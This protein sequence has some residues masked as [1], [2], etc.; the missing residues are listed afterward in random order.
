[1]CVRG[2]QVEWQAARAADWGSWVVCS[3]QACL[4]HLECLS[5]PEVHLWSA[6]LRVGFLADST[7]FPQ[8]SLWRERPPKWEGRW[9]DHSGALGP[10]SGGA[11]AAKKWG[12]SLHHHPL[13]CGAPLGQAGGGHAGP[14]PH[15]A[16]PRRTRGIH[17][18]LRPI[19]LSRHSLNH[20]G[21]G[22]A[23]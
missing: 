22:C 11:P 5:R 2:R 3:L 9:C 6:V 18:N 21:E 12:R 16:L 23:L 1:M 4:S 17:A 13:S 19:R 10:L 14:A 7:A 20:N 15:C 8:G